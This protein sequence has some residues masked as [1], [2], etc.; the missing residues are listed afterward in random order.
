MKAFLLF[1]LFFL[2]AAPFGQAADRTI[3]VRKKSEIVQDVVRKLDTTDP[4][5][6][7]CARIQTPVQEVI[8]KGGLVASNRQLLAAKN[9]LAIALGKRQALVEKSHTAWMLMRNADCEIEAASFTGTKASTSY[10]ACVIAAN[11]D[12]HAHLQNLVRAKGRR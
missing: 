9:E 2:F 3:I 7:D 10:I 6:F 12:R 1:L 4:Q 8:C 5:T 11:K